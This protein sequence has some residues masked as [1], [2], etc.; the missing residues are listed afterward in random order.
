MSHRITSLHAKSTTTRV[1]EF[2]VV[3][4]RQSPTIGAL[5][6]AAFAIGARLRAFSSAFLAGLAGLAAGGGAAAEAATGL[7]AIAATSA[8]STARRR[9]GRERRRTWGSFGR[10]RVDPRSP[11]VR[12]VIRGG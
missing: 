4:L 12:V 7:I 6:D 10:K 9:G 11:H 5:H 1:I 8:A 3:M 2:V